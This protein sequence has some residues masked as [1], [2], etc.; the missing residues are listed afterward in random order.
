MNFV[1][2]LNIFENTVFKE[3]KKRSFDREIVNSITRE[4]FE[5]DME[6]RYKYISKIRCAT[7]TFQ[8][9]EKKFERIMEKKHV[10]PVTDFTKVFL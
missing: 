10:T 6:F 8:N 2:F 4:I 3:T 5:F 9:F 1:N 7:L